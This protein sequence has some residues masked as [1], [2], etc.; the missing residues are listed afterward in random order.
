LR[1]EIPNIL[2][3]NVSL[4]INEAA[5]PGLM[6]SW[7]NFRVYSDCNLLAVQNL[8]LA[9]IRNGNIPILQI[10]TSSV[11]GAIVPDSEKSP[12]NPISPY[13][14]SKLAAENLLNAF[15]ISFGLPFTILRY[16]SVYGPRQR[17]DMAYNIISQSI[18]RG[19]V[20]NI[21]GDGRQTRTNTYVGDV[22]DGTILA[23]LGV[24]DHDIYNLAGQ[25]NISLIDAIGILEKAIGKR[26][27]IEFLPSRPGDQQSTMTSI[28]KAKDAFGYVPLT[29]IE[30][31]L[32]LQA[33]WHLKELGN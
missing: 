29:T 7:S 28:K 24:H 32:E 12:L 9:S 15:N 11:Y 3:S 27:K 20:V 19:E 2:L 25:E 1:N 26:A 14:V 13:G 17:P 31:G 8:A 18:I 22:V 21:Y 4:I 30:K 6:K 5:M 23:A 10:S 16:F 33:L